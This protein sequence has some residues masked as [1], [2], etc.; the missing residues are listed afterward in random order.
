MRKT[1]ST[2]W[3]ALA[4]ALALSLAPAGAQAVSVSFGD[5]V[6]YWA[7]HGNGTG[8][9]ARDTI[10]T[11]DLLG[12]SAHFE[13]GLLTQVR[14][15]YLGPFSLTGSGRGSV[16]AGDLFVD[17]GADGS[18]DYV[19]K[20]VAGPQ[21]AVA[22]YASVAILDVSGE[23]A[24]YLTSGQD[25][26]GHWRG[27][28]IRDDHPYA[29]AGGGVEIGTGSVGS[30]DPLANGL[31]TLVF[32]LGAGLVVGESFRLGFAASCGNDVLLEQVT[33]PV[34]EPSAALVFAAGLL[35]AARRPQRRRA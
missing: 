25:D 22:S 21:T 27:F 17:A 33:A 20:L 9:D 14:I 11:P 19:M 31:H 23:P 35:L 16:I 15:D 2:R 1:T 12:G 18:W 7:G 32:D 10:G 24:S 29:W 5:S 13:G 28:L 30:P 6:H 34:P 8:D 26:T 4:A 3:R